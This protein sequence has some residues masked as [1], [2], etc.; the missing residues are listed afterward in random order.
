VADTSTP[1]I[2]GYRYFEAL[3]IVLFL[4][5]EGVLLYG[6]WEGSQAHPD[7][8]A[9]VM[10]AALL[11]AVLASDFVSGLF[12]FLADNFGDENTPILGPNVI[13]PFREHHVLPRKMVEHG[14]VETNGNNCLICLPAQ[15]AVYCLIPATAS[16]LFL[17][18]ATFL[19]LF[20]VGIFLTNQFHKWA[21]LERTPGWL[22]V[23]QK[24]RL[25]LNPEQHDVHHTP[26]FDR[27]YCITT[28]WLNPVLDWL[29]FFSRLEATI[30]W[31]TRSPDPKKG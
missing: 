6:V 8:A 22:A 25:I 29:G 4:A 12:H 27:Y 11:G 17:F 3:A 5:F 15:V 2:P 18:L 10:S 7:V 23:L 19:S 24:T 30:R 20:F 13:G 28:G 9:W 1:G 14:F 16:P 26:P 31:V 21:H